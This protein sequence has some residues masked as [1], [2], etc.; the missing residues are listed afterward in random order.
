[1][2]DMLSNAFQAYLDKE[3]DLKKDREI[4]EILLQTTLTAAADDTAMEL[5]ESNI[6]PNNVNDLKDLINQTLLENKNQRKAHEQV[7]DARGAVTRKAKAK[8]QL[9]KKQVQ[10]TLGKESGAPSTKKTRQPST[11]VNT[12][13]SNQETSKKKRKSQKRK[14]PG[15]TDEVGSDSENGRKSRHKKNTKRN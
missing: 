12:E 5:D 9:K 3:A 11:T 13:V 1:M 2:V 4:Q 8:K 6:I 15:S 7:K 14:G 10:F